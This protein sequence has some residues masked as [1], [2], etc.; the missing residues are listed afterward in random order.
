MGDG[1]ISGRVLPVLICSSS[2]LIFFSS[3]LHLS[4]I[5]PER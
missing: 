2:H 5:P 3:D 1:R 4:K